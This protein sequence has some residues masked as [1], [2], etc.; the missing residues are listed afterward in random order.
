[1]LAS[2]SNSARPWSWITAT[3]AVRC[4]ILREGCRAGGRI[5]LRSSASNCR[6]LLQYPLTV[7][8]CAPK[9]NVR[10]SVE[11]GSRQRER[12]RSYVQQKQ[13]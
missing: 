9:P 12:E 11:D 5:P 6:A 8:A 1:M 13:T 3:S 7:P 4:A 10:S 2:L